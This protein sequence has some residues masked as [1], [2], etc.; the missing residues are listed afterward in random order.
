MFNDI[1]KSYFYFDTVAGHCAYLSEEQ[2]KL[3]LDEITTYEGLMR[4]LYKTKC[5]TCNSWVHKNG[6]KRHLLSKS[7]NKKMLEN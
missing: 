1:K 7:H 3:L 4:Q 2:I 5:N 6:F